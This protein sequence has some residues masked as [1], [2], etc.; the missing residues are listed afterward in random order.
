M[1]ALALGGGPLLAQARSDALGGA[2][3]RSVSFGSGLGIASLKELAVPLGLAIPMGSRLSLDAG[4]FFVSAQSQ[5]GAG[6]STT[7]NGLTDVI[8]HGAYQIRPD[9]AVLTFSASVPTGHK[10]LSG[11]QQQIA[12][13]V[14]TDLVPFPVTNFGSSFSVTT[15]LAYATP[16]G[17][18]A[19]GLAGSFRYASSYQPISDSGFSTLTI[20]PGAEMRLRLGA[21]RIV[22]QGRLSLGVTYSTF[23]NDEIGS[24]SQSPGTRLIPQFTWS[25]PMGRNN[26]VVFYG[27][28]VYRNVDE[29]ASVT[30]AVRQNTFA[31]GASAS[32]RSGANTLQPLFELRKG[33]QGPGGLHNAG[34]LVGLGLRYQMAAGE[35][36]TLTPGFRLDLGNLATSSGG[37]ASVSGLSVSLTARTS[38]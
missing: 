19:L 8:V 33:W 3:Y 14:A 34:T 6:S 30:G 27:W 12:N 31:L 36:M 37:S 1:S 17:P 24:Q 35:R 15:G 28:D 20:K 7:I 10:T 25:T 2:E 38:F 32:L 22:G 11:Q 9:V 23:S 13:A 26:S 29:S 21:D 5:D 4:T 16:V 18:W